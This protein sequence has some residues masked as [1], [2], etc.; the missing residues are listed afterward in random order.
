[1]DW[2]TAKANTAEAKDRAE[3]RPGEERIAVHTLA[4]ILSLAFL[5]ATKTKPPP[6]HDLGNHNFRS[7]LQQ[8]HR[9]QCR[10][11]LYYTIPIVPMLHPTLRRPIRRTAWYT[12]VPV[13]RYQFPLLL[14]ASRHRNSP[15]AE[16]ENSPLVPHFEI[17]E[18]V[19]Q[20]RLIMERQ[21]TARAWDERRWCCSLLI[22]PNPYAVH[23]SDTRIGQ[24][25][26]RHEMQNGL[27]TPLHCFCASAL[28][29]TALDRP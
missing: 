14:S 17:A 21:T 25:I 6:D 12:L 3:P 15:Q 26:S 20:G 9:I 22:R 11:K 4:E 24:G 5:R 19:R 18:K 10:R 2:N 8:L 27:G 16:A 1:M 7:R 28:R 23:I 13:A 29:P